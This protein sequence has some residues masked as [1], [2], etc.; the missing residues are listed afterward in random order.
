MVVRPIAGV[1]V[2]WI[3]DLYPGQERVGWAWAVPFIER[4]STVSVC[5][6]TGRTTSV[7]LA[8][9]RPPGASI[10]SRGY[11]ECATLQAAKELLEQAGRP[12]DAVTPFEQEPAE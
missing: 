12:V 3:V 7:N 6:N 11:Y 1:N 10:I 9:I 4:S 5:W 2:R 8:S